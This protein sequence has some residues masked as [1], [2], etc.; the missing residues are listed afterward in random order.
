MENVVDH[1]V[2]TFHP[3]KGI[4]ECKRKL[5]AKMKTDQMSGIYLPEKSS[6][7]LIGGDGHCKL[8]D[9]NL[10]MKGQYYCARLPWHRGK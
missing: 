8:Y 10:Q 7:I 3:T 4:Q 9:G 6:H 2:F 5:D 1:V